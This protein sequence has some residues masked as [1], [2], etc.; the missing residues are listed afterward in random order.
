L[1][2]YIPNQDNHPVDVVID[3]L[4]RLGVQ[5][6]VLYL[7]ADIIRRLGP[8]APGAFIRF[9]ASHDGIK[10]RLSSSVKT[11]DVLIMI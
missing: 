9:G 5:V 3:A 4:D 2:W 1:E 6:T 7:I 8:C 11:I 10:P